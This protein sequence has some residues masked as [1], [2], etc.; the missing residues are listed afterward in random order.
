MLNDLPAH[1][2]HARKPGRYIGTEPDTGVEWFIRH[3]GGTYFARRF[4]EPTALEFPSLAEISRKLIKDA[5][6]A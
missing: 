5:H 6:H 3:L 2:S 1:I 4:N